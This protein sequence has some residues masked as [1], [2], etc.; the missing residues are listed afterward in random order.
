[1]DGQTEKQAEKII[2]SHYR[3][4]KSFPFLK[5]QIQNVLFHFKTSDEV[6]ITESKKKRI[7]CLDNGEKVTVT[8]VSTLKRGMFY[9][10]FLI[11]GLVS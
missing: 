6:I 8:Y 4:T 7:Y 9:I 2:L 5:D 11:R 1:M 3:E 10:A